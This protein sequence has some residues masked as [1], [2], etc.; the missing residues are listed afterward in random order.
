MDI[1]LLV[2]LVVLVV[3]LFAKRKRDTRDIDNP[4]ALSKSEQKRV[5]FDGDFVRQPNH[6]GPSSASAN[7]EYNVTWRDNY[8]ESGQV[9]LT[10][11]QGETLWSAELDRPNNACVSN[12]GH[13]AVEDWRRGDSLRGTFYVF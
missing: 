11:R 5:E 6:L 8:Y 2:A 4:I 10:N 13:V 7:R 12:R 9:I 3:Y 1:L